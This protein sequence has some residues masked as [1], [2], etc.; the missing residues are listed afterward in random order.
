MKKYAIVFLGII[1]AASFTFSEVK[2]VKVTAERGSLFSGPSASSGLMDT[3]EKGAVLNVFGSG[4][5]NGW[6]YVSGKSARLR[7]MI[8]GYIHA[9]QVEIIAEEM[10]N[11][12]PEVLPEAPKIEEAAKAQETVIPE[13]VVPAKVEQ[14]AQVQ[15]SIKPEEKKS[16][17]TEEP[18][19][20]EQIDKSAQILPDKKTSMPAA[21]EEKPRKRAFSIHFGYNAGFASQNSSVSWS[22]QLYHEDS[23]YGIN[24]SAKKGNSFNAGIGYKF[25]QSVGVE[26]GADITSRALNAN[27]NASIPHPLYFNSP[28]NAEGTASFNISEN[29]VYLRIVLSIP[30]SRF[31]I[32]L[33]GGPAYFSSSAEVIGTIQYSQS[34][35][36]SSVNISAQN[37]KISKSAFGF[38]G[39]AS[40]LFYFSRGFGIFLGGQYYS[41]SAVFN[42]SDVPGLKLSLGGL[43]AGG[44][45]KIFF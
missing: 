24:Y 21:T 31:S 3:F 6:Y 14:P 40:L 17:K 23:G 26:V 34:Y 13:E 35:P 42:P 11:P 22:G 45:I 1:L 4:E 27:Y 9:S 39:G 41:A 33:F 37:Q 8:T 10:P 25:A 2:K 44:G 38:N 36:Y 28:R 18:S 16:G 7:S 5:K 15:E 32:D 29:A 30:F 20:V 19:K 12:R 43:K